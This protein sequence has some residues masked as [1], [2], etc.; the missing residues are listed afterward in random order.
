MDILIKAGSVVLF[1]LQELDLK[2]DLEQLSDEMNKSDLYNI[3]R[4][5]DSFSFFS[6]AFKQ[7]IMSDFNILDIEQHVKKHVSFFLFS[8]SESIDLKNIWEA[9]KGIDP[10]FNLKSLNSFFS[11]IDLVPRKARISAL[12]PKHALDKHID[13]SIEHAVRIHMPLKSS[14]NCFFYQEQSENIRKYQFTEGK[15][16]AIN[17]GVPHFVENQ[18]NE[19]R[20]HLI[21][22]ILKCDYYKIGLKNV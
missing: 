13:F 6:T 19:I 8:K 3:E 11:K 9:T 4:Y 17:V 15:M 2:L 5:S 16:Y 10:K 14:S 12:M 20:F 7:S 21:F 18:S 22:D 1:L